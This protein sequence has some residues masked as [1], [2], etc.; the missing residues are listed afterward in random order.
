MQALSNSI[1]LKTEFTHK[2]AKQVTLMIKGNFMS[3]S[4]IIEISQKYR[5]IEL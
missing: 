3:S 5:N 1:K 4:K 2:S